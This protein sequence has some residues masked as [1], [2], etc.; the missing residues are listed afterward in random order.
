ML[1]KQTQW[2]LLFTNVVQIYITF[3]LL[4]LPGTVQ[5]PPP[6]FVVWCKTDLPYYESRE[7]RSLCI[8]AMFD[9]CVGQHSA[10]FTALSDPDVVVSSKLAGE[11]HPSWAGEWRSVFDLRHLALQVPPRAL[12]GPLYPPRPVFLWTRPQ[13]LPTKSFRL[14]TCFPCGGRE[15]G[16]FDGGHTCAVSTSISSYIRRQCAFASSAVVL[17]RFT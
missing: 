1:S 10:F 17:Q 9:R 3:F 7:N 16:L 11:V 2:V 6:N 8:G 5:H 15:R 12:R 4:M 13:I 14:A